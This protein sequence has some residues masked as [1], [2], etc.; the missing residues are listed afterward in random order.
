M[1]NPLQAR[2]VR[3][4]L[5]AVAVLLIAVAL[6]VTVALIE[7]LP[8]RTIVMATGAQGGAYAEVARRYQAILARNGVRLELR[9]SHGSV[10][11]LELLRD[12]KS[13]VS[14]ALAQGGLTSPPES[15]DV[16]SLGTVFYEPVWVFLRGT[17]LPQP[18]SRGF[19]GRG[20]IGQPGSGTRALAEELFAALGQDMS[21][22]RPVDMT[23]A[24]AGEALLRGELDLAV[25]VS[26]WEAP[27]VRRLLTAPGI[28]TMSATRADAQVAL[29]PH[30]GKLVLPRGVGDLARDRPPGDVQLLAVKASLL[31]R[32]DLHPAIQYLL[33]EAAAEA[34]GAPGIFHRAGQFPAAEPADLP[35]SATALQYYRSGVPWLQRNLPFWL[36]SIASQLLVLLI[37]IVGVI[38]PIF[39]LLPALFDW[40]MR[41][42]IFHLY[43]ELKFLEAEI[44]ALGARPAGPELHA[45]LEQLEQR[46]NHMHVPQAFAHM[47]YTLRLHIG[48]VRKRITT[49]GGSD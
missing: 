33:L 13:R 29:H 3:R 32:K 8:P 9:E 12:P 18:G 19:E 16:R 5:V 10:E 34:H 30:L 4:V 21:L 41:R 6:V 26:G 39:R 11:N 48:I 24:E 15:P 28:T 14:V 37:P 1:R 7:P 49:Q 45:K 22:I 17:N 36:A 27:I 47:V 20:S 44:D 31:V 2:R 25:I 42:R 40:S 46:A 38:Y 23:A 35:L 43:G